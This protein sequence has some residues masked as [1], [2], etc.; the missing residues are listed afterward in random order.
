[1]VT[2]ITSDHSFG[3][4]QHYIDLLAQGLADRGNRV[5]I[6]TT[7]L[8]EGKSDSKTEKINGNITTYFLK[9]TRP[10]SYRNGFFKKAYEKFLEINEQYKI[11]LV[12]GQS[13]AALGFINKTVPVPVIT[14]LFGVGYCET[15]YQRLIFPKLQ[16]REKLT[17]FYKLPKIAVSIRLMHKAAE[18]SDRVILISEFSRRELMRIRPSFP[19]HKLEVIHCGIN[20]INFDRSSKKGLKNSLG[21]TGTLV[22]SAGRVEVQKGVHVLLDAWKRLEPQNAT[23]AVV[24][25][26]SYLAYLK[27][28]AERRGISNCR[29]AGSLPYKEFLTYFGAADLFVYPELTQPAFGL[30]AAQALAHAVPVIGSSH[31]AIPEVVGD[32]GL[33]FDPG[34]SGDLCEKMEY[35][36]DHREIWEYLGKKGQ[37]RVKSL[38][39]TEEMVK[40]TLGLYWMC[41]KKKRR[42]T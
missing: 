5:F 19:A 13:A 12:H 29:F 28:Y 38:F 26:G 15:P 41:I 42:N 14:T 25:D 20:A 9:N 21:I 17:F 6:I 39:S 10:G 11:D 18:G 24:G 30:V 23:L 35:F 33:L 22:L 40:R 31:G 32:A 34:L 7:A 8:P 36:L 4:M 27:K 3:G 37:Q 16:I 2:R 1:M